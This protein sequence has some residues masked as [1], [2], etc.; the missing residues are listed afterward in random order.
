MR[1]QAFM[2]FMALLSSAVLR[3]ATG[4]QA[5]A[6]DLVRHHLQVWVALAR[7]IEPGEGALAGVSILELHMSCH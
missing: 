5:S 7:P 1:A 2:A 6:G 4:L 3:K